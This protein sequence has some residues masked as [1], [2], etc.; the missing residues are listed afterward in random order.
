MSESEDIEIK[1]V[2]YADGL[3]TPIEL[4]RNLT[5]D[6]ID[7][8][9]QT[10]TFVGGTTPA[11]V[12]NKA[13]AS[14]QVSYRGQT[15]FDRFTTEV[16]EIMEAMARFQPADEHMKVAPESRIQG[17]ESNFLYIRWNPLAVCT[18]GSPTSMS[19]L[20]R[21]VGKKATSVFPRIQDY[22][23]YFNYLGGGGIFSF[24]IPQKDQQIKYILVSCTGALGALQDPDMQLTLEN[25]TTGKRVFSDKHWDDLSRSAESKFGYQHNVGL[26]IIPVNIKQNKM[27]SYVLKTNL[28]TPSSPTIIDILVVSQF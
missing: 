23:G 6:Y 9:G 2:D 21:I 17:S 1:T 13:I 26:L 25:V 4:P 12:A 14:V 7:I 3:L 16:R 27:E 5:L 28:L 22:R 20:H 18:T 15:F 8:L 24:T 11:Y 10:A 19:M